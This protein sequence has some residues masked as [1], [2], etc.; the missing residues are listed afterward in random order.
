MH[1]HIPIYT[2]QHRVRSY[3][4]QLV[5]PAVN[6]THHVDTINFYIKT[7]DTSHHCSCFS[8]DISREME[9]LVLVVSPTP[10]ELIKRI[11]LL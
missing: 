9:C 5:V 1:V 4:W 11:V 7:V 2:E 6:L 10:V 8:V 3:N